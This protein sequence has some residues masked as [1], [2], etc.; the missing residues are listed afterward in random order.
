MNIVEA[1]RS[2]ISSFFKKNDGYATYEEASK[3]YELAEEKGRLAST[4][5]SSGGRKIGN[6]TF[7]VRNGKL[8]EKP[9]YSIK[10]H[11]TN[12][13]TLLPNGDYILD[14]E[15]WRTPLTKSRFET[16]LPIS[17]WNHKGKW[18]FRKRGS[19]DPDQDAFLFTDGM[20]LDKQCRPLKYKQIAYYADKNVVS[21]RDNIQFISDEPTLKKILRTATNTDIVLDGITK[22]HD[23]KF[24][25]KL[26]W[27][28][29]TESVLEKVNTIDTHAVKS[30]ISVCLKKIADIETFA[31][32][33][34]TE[35]E[36][37]DDSCQSKTLPLLIAK[38]KDQKF[39]QKYIED[40][41]K[42]YM[43]GKTGVWVLI[44]A[45]AKRIK[46]QKFLINLF[47]RFDLSVA[48]EKGNS[49][50]SL[51]ELLSVVIKDD[52]FTK[53]CIEKNIDDEEYVLK[54]VSKHSILE[55]EA[56]LRGLLEK[57]IGYH[58]ADI[59]FRALVSFHNMD[60]KQI[61]D[62]LDDKTKSD[63]IK[64]AAKK[65]Y[66]QSCKDVDKL[67]KIA[68]EE[69]HLREKVLET[70]KKLDPEFVAKM[71][72]RKWGSETFDEDIKEKEEDQ[73]IYNYKK[74]LLRLLLPLAV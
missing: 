71:K 22:I 7:I 65:Y 51:S 39:L 35:I 38:I 28:W 60:E 62:I 67:K 18:Y 19:Y 48:L 55:D 32:K 23:E 49:H 11:N 68:L 8:D 45:A 72:K 34:L 74:Q 37:A 57:K 20:V 59:V 56:F 16:Y 52:A 47:E 6:N 61:Q 15:G 73:K 53:M 10:L 58:V 46:N 33:V 50:N 24:I 30:I 42:L 69:P 25:K 12:I 4:G 17:I 54:Q 70:L 66:I 64:K 41:L 27:D 40:N 63:S 31:K 13:I 21:L 2:G 3:L 14:T 9:V 29:L 36:Y 26:A 43:S 44:V 5:Y 1:F